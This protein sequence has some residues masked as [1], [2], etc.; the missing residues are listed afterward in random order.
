MPNITSHLGLAWE[1][2]ENL[3]NP[4]LEQHLGS[5]LLGAAS[6]DIR[7][8]TRQP[9]D[10]THFSFLNSETIDVG[11]LEMLDRYPKIAKKENVSPGTQAFIA[12][13]ITHLITDQVWIID[14]Y[15]PFFGNPL[16]Y[17]DQV[18]GNVMDRALQLEMDSHDRPIWGKATPL[19]DGVEES[20]AVEFIEPP[21][22]KQWREWVQEYG[23][24]EFTWERLHFLARRQ[25]PEG[26]TRAQE[27]VE[28]FLSSLT[29]GL[30]TLH[31]VVSEQRV[32]QF[33]KRAK[34]EFKRIIEEYLR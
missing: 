29:D 5:Y 26:D 9:R 24:R 8:I 22:L 6:P 7:I 12:G 14:I 4:I 17:K 27:L 11:V 33:R 23:E 13:Y 25:Y 18:L 34:S 31:K 10:A 19:L 32:A 20:I 2:L 15:R 21:V 28:G 30:N 3:P 16:V 1:A